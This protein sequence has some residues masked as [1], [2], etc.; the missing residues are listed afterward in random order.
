MTRPE[1]SS[2]GDADKTCRV[3]ARGRRCGVV[4]TARRRPEI[5]S[6]HDLRGILGGNWID[7]LARALHNLAEAQEPYLQEY[8][9]QNPRVHD[10]REGKTFTSAILPRYMRRASSIDAL[11]PALYLKGVSTS[12]F[13]QALSAILG[14]NAVGLSPGNIVRLKQTCLCVSARRQVWDE[15][16]Q[17]GSFR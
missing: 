7:C 13:P 15:E 17:A 1:R 10:R 2:V 12:A 4:R 3:G 11:I 9:R 6:A 16:Y 8:Y 5:R 14:D